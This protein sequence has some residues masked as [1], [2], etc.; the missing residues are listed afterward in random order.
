MLSWNLR[1]STLSF[2]FPQVSPFAFFACLLSVFF[3]CCC[4]CFFLPSVV[5]FSTVFLAY[6]PTFIVNVF[7]KYYN[8]PKSECD[9]LYCGKAVKYAK[10]SQLPFYSMSSIWRTKVSSG[11]KTHFIE[12]YDTQVQFCTQ[13]RKNVRLHPRFVAQKVTPSS[14]H[15]E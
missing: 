12:E 8:Y 13:T 7:K 2:S 3:G 10:I 15:F 5:L 4:C 1:S 9:Y 11:R 6:S 14:H